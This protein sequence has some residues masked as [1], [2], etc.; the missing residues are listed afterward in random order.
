MHDTKK[1]YT[2]H[3][4]AYVKSWIVLLKRVII[5]GEGSHHEICKVVHFIESEG[6]NK[7]YHSRFQLLKSMNFFTLYIK[8]RPK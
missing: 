2:K 4:T 6:N 5:V 8:K 3:G 1:H 7:S